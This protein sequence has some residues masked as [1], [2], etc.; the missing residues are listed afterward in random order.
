MSRDVVAASLA[1]HAVLRRVGALVLVGAVLASGMMAGPGAVAA[2][3]DNASALAFDGASGAVVRVDGHALVRSLDGGRH[4]TELALPA[5]AR[6]R[7]IAAVAVAAGEKGVL[8][9]AITDVG[10]LRSDDGGRGWSTRN[11]GLPALNVT[12]LAAHADQAATVY[13]H[14]AGHGIFRSE[15]GG[16]HWKLMDAGPRE[17]IVGLI[18]SNMPGSMQSGC[19]FAATG[20]GGQRAMDCF[21]GWRDAGGLDRPVR[22]L[23]YDP[24]EPRRVWAATDDGLYLSTDGGEGWSRAKGP[25]EKL[26][27]LLTT[28]AGELFAVANGGALYR[29]A[30][31]AR[32]WER[33]DA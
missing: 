30:D 9:A 28:P 25:A 14:V 21:C 22:A 29:S 18:H 19:L 24:R 26:D 3:G 15:D 5:D 27:A 23:A 8:Y 13:A 12:A 31:G 17:P 6:G 1:R 16:L 10:V 32:T 4:R 33:P 2:A 7:S 11:A 20:K